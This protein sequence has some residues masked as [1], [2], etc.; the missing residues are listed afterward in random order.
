[1]EVEAM[2]SISSGAGGGGCGGV[3]ADLRKVLRG[4]M[5]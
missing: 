5:A 3:S 2:G 4:G 1:M